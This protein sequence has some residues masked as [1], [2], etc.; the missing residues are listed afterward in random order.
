MAASTASEK[1]PEKES[2]VPPTANETRLLGQC[3]KCSKQ[4]IEEFDKYMYTYNSQKPDVKDRIYC[5]TWGQ[6]VPKAGF[7]YLCGGCAT[8]A[9][10][11]RFEKEPIGY[12]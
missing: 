11:K 8:S 5:I 12:G 3:K 10:R 7:Y 1:Q 2:P 6:N 4:L 9:Q